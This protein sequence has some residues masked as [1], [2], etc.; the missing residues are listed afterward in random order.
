MCQLIIKGK[1]HGVFPFVVQIRDRNNHKVI[2][3][4]ELGTIG[5]KMGWNTIDNGW[6]RFKKIKIPRTNMLMR[7]SKVDRDGTFTKPPHDRIA[8]STMLWI[9]ASF[10]IHSF[11]IL[12]RAV[13]ISIRYSCVRRQGWLPGSDVGKDKENKVLEYKTQQYRLFPLLASSYCIFF[14]GKSIRKMYTNLVSDIGEGSFE[15]LAEAHATTCSLKTFTTWLVA[16]G[17]EEC[18]ERC[19]GLGYHLF[20]GIPQLIKKWAVYTVG[21]GDNIL[22][23]QQTC[24]FLLKAFTDEKFSKRV[25]YLSKEFPNRCLADKEEC[26]LNSELLLQLY[27]HRAKRE[28]TSLARFFELNFSQGKK[29]NEIW[30]ESM[31]QMINVSQSHAWFVCVNWFL[32]GLNDISDENIKNVLLKLFYLFSLHGIDS[33]SG[34]FLIDGLLSENQI[35]LIKSCISN[36]LKEIRSFAVNLVDAFDFPDFYLNSALGVKK[37]NVYQTVLDMQKN[38]PLNSSD[39]TPSYQLFSKPLFEIFFVNHKDF[40]DL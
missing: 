23:T 25:P 24:K 32:D 29:M 1:K 13:T 26:F 10:V 28:V 27:S 16:K 38:D 37:G 31:P 6:A 3:G 30:N 12:A 33:N 35:L 14:V 19:G 20:S 18:R 5:P 36:L 17:L 34:D 15:T 8:Y 40:C 9:R 21:E 4:V 11:Y 22:L 7:F 2:Q 39:V